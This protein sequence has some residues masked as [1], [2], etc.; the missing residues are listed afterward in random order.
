[1]LIFLLVPLSA[2]AMAGASLV[3]GFVFSVA[4]AVLTSASRNEVLVAMSVY[5]GL[6]FLFVGNLSRVT[7]EVPAASP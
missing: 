6:L 2:R 5:C 4:F 1:M 7:L 3:F